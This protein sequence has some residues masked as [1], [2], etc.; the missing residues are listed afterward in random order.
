MDGKYIKKDTLADRCNSGDCVTGFGLYDWASGAYYQG[1]WRND[2]RCFYGI[3][4]FSSGSE[5][6]GFWQMDKKNGFGVHTFSNGEKYTGYFKKDLRHGYGEFIFE[7]ENK[8]VGEFENDSIYGEGVMYYA[9]GKIERGFW[10][11]DK[12]TRLQKLGF[13]CVSGDCWY[14]YGTYIAKNGDRYIGEW[15]NSKYSGK[16]MLYET[17]GNIYVGEFKEGLKEGYGKQIYNNGERYLGTWKKNYIDGRG[18]YVY[19]NDSVLHAL[20]RE[21]K[22]IVKAPQN[23]DLPKIMW[24]VPLTAQSTSNSGNVKLKFGLTSATALS[25]VQIFVNEKLV[26]NLAQFVLSTQ[27]LPEYDFTIEKEIKL[28]AGA[29]EIKILAINDFGEE[30][31][32][33]RMINFKQNAKSKKQALL[34]ANSYNNPK[35]AYFAENAKLLENFLLAQNYEI[36]TLI[37]PQRAQLEKALREFGES[38]QQ[39]QEGSFFYFGGLMK[40][41]SSKNYFIL[42]NDSIATQDDVILFGIELTR[43]YDE[44]R[45]GGSQANFAIL[46]YQVPQ[47]KEPLFSLNGEIGL[48]PANPPL[49]TVVYFSTMPGTEPGKSVPNNSFLPSFLSNQKLSDYQKMFES[50]KIYVSQITNSRQIPFYLENNSKF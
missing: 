15:I 19:R 16:G 29:N 25:N 11:G 42:S 23:P 48:Y 38:I 2:R 26:S 24:E 14:G 46:D 1:F 10:I 27:P 5:Y 49:N 45:Y 30:T 50:A 3:N 18:M 39:N 37:N 9:D 43:L 4:R 35:Y 12:L 32:D 13:G 44:I 7:N 34:I 31:S 8:F 21:G 47:Y 41:F 28:E 33:I 6:R 36:I 40:Q 20:W 22:F 17:N